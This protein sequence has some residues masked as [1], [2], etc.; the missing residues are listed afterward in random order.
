MFIC[1]E[2]WIHFGFWRL[3]SECLPWFQKQ[4]SLSV[5][6]FVW[7]TNYQLFSVALADLM[8]SFRATPEIMGRWRELPMAETPARYPS[9]EPFVFFKSIPFRFAMTLFIICGCWITLPEKYSFWVVDSSCWLLF[10]AACRRALRAD[11]RLPC[12][13]WSADCC[14]AVWRS[15]PGQTELTILYSL[16][17][18]F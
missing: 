13:F 2:I 7:S 11:R 4:I 16:S 1:L 6:H 3:E 12:R 17:V 9:I 18:M 10:G 8:G 5:P 15:R 14:V